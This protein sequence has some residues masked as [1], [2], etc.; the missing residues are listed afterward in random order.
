M[1]H[2]SAR[3]GRLLP[4][5]AATAVLLASLTACNGDDKPE[6]QAPGDRPTSA[7]PAPQEAPVEPTLQLPGKLKLGDMLEVTVEDGEL[8]KVVVRGE[9]QGN[10]G[11][12]EDKMVKLPGQLTDGVWTATT[13]PE[14]STLYRVKATLTDGTVLEGTVNSQTVALDK[15]AF[16]SLFPSGGT[17]GIGQPVVVRFDVPVKNRTEAE[18]HLKVEVTPA[19]AGAWH[20]YSDTEVR[21]RPK[22]YWKAGTTVK[23]RADLNSQNLGG[24]VFGQMDRAATFKVGKAWRAEVNMGTQRMRVFQGDKLVR[25]LPVSTGKPGF[26]T[27]SGVKLIMSKH[28]YYDMNSTSIGIDPNSSE[29]YDLSDVEYAMRLTNSG[30]FIHA[31]PWNSGLFGVRAGSHGCVGLSTSDTAWLFNNLPVGTP[32]EF[33]GNRKMMTPENGWGDWNLSW[34]QLN[35]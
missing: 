20:W 23:V 29:G 34:K 10:F 8:Q 30:E 19:Q 12:A 21:Y 27:R 4:T 5:A 15:Q 7:T 16:A 25:D 18:K 14:P 28:R 17:Y 13:R 22:T 1:N 11:K 3:M 32:I 6:A 24:G 31:A 35:S 33:K 9:R 26:D 2:R